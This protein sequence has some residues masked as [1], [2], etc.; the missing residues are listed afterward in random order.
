MSLASFGELRH[1]T[2]QCTTSSPTESEL[3]S[4]VADAWC[5]R[6]T[7]GNCLRSREWHPNGPLNHDQDPI[8]AERPGQG[9]PVRIRGRDRQPL[10]NGPAARCTTSTTTSGP[11]RRTAIAAGSAPSG[12][13]WRNGNRGGTAAARSPA[14]RCLNPPVLL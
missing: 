4:A 7:G 3:P 1:H 10:T 2:W 14:I 9:I 11:A 5:V 13:T 8:S 6:E 12:W